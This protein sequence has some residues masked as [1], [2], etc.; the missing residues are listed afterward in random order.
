MESAKNKTLKPVQEPAYSTIW[1]RAGMSF[2]LTEEEIQKIQ[3]NPSCFTSIMT[4]VFA[5]QRYEFDGE[6]Y[7]PAEAEENEMLYTNNNT[8]EFSF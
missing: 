6:T 1:G 3:S 7:F 5:E 8:I 2:K 4:V